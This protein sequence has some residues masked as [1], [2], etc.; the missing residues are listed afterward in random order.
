MFFYSCVSL[1]ERC[2]L[3][4]RLRTDTELDDYPHRSPMAGEL[5]EAPGVLLTMRP[6]WWMWIYTYICICIYIYIYTRI[7]IYMQIDSYSY[8]CAQNDHIISCIY[9]YIYMQYS[10]PHYHEIC[11]SITYVFSFP[12]L[13]RKVPPHLPAQMCSASKYFILLLDPQPSAAASIWAPAAPVSPCLIHWEGA[14]RHGNWIVPTVL[15]REQLSFVFHPQ[16]R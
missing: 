14:E 15:P 10:T 6:L 1:P 7:Y 9:I 12:C 2:A 11:W 5:S 8:I 13:S 4:E 16:H 3:I